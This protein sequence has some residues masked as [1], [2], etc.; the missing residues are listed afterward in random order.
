MSTRIGPM[1]AFVAARAASEEHGIEGRL[2]LV[3]VTAYGRL[4]E[5]QRAGGAGQAASA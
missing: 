2:E 3:D 1:A 5:L 4:R